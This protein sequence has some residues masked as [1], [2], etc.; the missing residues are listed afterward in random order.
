MMPSILCWRQNHLIQSSTMAWTPE[1]LQA[2]CKP[3]APNWN[4]WDIQL[5][6][7]TTGVP[8]SLPNNHYWTTQPKVC[9]PI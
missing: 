8:A 5:H 6:R 2:S 9:T 3:S 7:A 1:A 4:Y